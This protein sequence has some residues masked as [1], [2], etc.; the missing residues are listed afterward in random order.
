MKHIIEVLKPDML[1]MM[2]I[3]ITPWK[4]AHKVRMED[5]Y[6]RLRIEK[7]TIK[8]WKT[9]KEEVV[10]YYTLFEHEREKGKNKLVRILIKGN[11]GIGKTTLARKIMYDWANNEWKKTKMKDITLAFLVTLKYIKEHQEL[12]DMILEQHPALT[13]DKE[14]DKEVLGKLL[15]KYGKHIL[16]IIEGF[17]EIPTEFNENIENILHNRTYRDCISL[18]TSRPNT[19][20]S[21]EEFMTTIASIEGFSKENTRKYI[22]KVIED[23]TKRQA[24]YLYTQNSAIEEMWRY[25]I[26]VLFLCL[27]VNWG[28][29]NLSQENLQVGEFYTRLLN[30][31]Y[32]R[33]IAERVQMT[34][35][36]FEQSKRE[37]V[38]L[39]LGKVALDSLLANTMTYR[40]QDIIENVGPD[41]FKYGILI[42]TD[43]WEGR[44]DLPENADV[45]VFFAHRSI[46]EYLAAKYLIHQLGSHPSVSSI[47][48]NRG[49]LEFLQNNLMFLTFCAHFVSKQSEATK[50]QQSTKNHLVKFITDCLNHQTVKLEGISIYEES[51]WLFLEA[52]PKCTK[53]QHLKFNNLT[54]RCSVPSLLKGLGKSLQTLHFES[55]VVECEGEET[56]KSISF[57]NLKTVTFSGERGAIST[58]LSSAFKNVETL[59]VKT[60]NLNSEDVTVIDKANSKGYLKS[61]KYIEGQERI[62]KEGGLQAMLAHSWI[63]LED[64]NFMEYK[65]RKG[66]LEAL[67]Q[68][69]SKGFLPALGECVWLDVCDLPGHEIDFMI[70]NCKRLPAFD[71]FGITKNCHISDK[72]TKLLSISKVWIHLKCFHLDSCNL[73]YGDIEAIGNAN[74]NGSLPNVN[75][76]CLSENNISGSVNALLIHKWPR[77]KMADLYKCNLNSY[78]MAAIHSARRKGFLPSIDLS[79]TAAMYMPIIPAYHGAWENETPYLSE[80][81]FLSKTHLD[82]KVKFLG[83]VHIPIIPIMCGSWESEEELDLRAYVLSDQNMTAISEANKVGKLASVEEI[84]MLGKRNLSGHLGTLLNSTWKRLQSMNLQECD[85]T[86]GDTTALSKANVPCLR[87]LSLAR[88]SKVSGQIDTLFRRKWNLLEMLDLGKCCLTLKDIKALSDANKNG[89][90]PCLFDLRLWENRE[91]SGNVGVLL[92]NTWHNLEKLNL[93]M[94]NLIADDIM[95]LSK[96]NTKGY[97]PCLHRLSL[98]AN[99]GISNGLSVLLQHCWQ[100][101]EELLINDCHLTGNDIRA[102]SDANGMGNIP[103]LRVLQLAGY[104]DKSSAIS[105]LVDHEWPNLQDLCLVNCHL[106]QADRKVLKDAFKHAVR[107]DTYF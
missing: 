87:R 71:R 35:R 12:E 46:Q 47:M 70:A 66:D 22:E 49:S 63:K 86:E 98:D 43:E 79:C 106:I 53:I 77:L 61:V 91:L 82:Q 24:A 21:I 8:P 17:D 50:N 96:A 23:E 89:N 44:R 1:Q 32:R 2:K 51:S 5:L 59:D 94:C 58:L 72:M 57:P 29:I 74:K 14:V 84:Y 90:L 40:K 45:F 26:L 11:P 42:G 95:S 13:Y 81:E 48:G 4:E 64:L 73:T 36:D 9:E 88:N 28:E 62:W 39:K 18:V 69:N 97:L 76:I 25:P 104:R 41:A 100:T 92:C 38:L 99:H 83:L 16:V 68:A 6:T 34:E 10:D 54:F 101:L 15:E 60:Y 103:Y 52:L 105:K 85:L 27:L 102:L 31:L 20:E 37:E 55:C 75:Y 7:H 19:V 80:C 30:C 107:L 56:D 78:D 3:K 67:A 65:L 33:F 93:V